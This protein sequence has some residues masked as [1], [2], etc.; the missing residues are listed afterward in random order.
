MSPS[1]TK[2]PTPICVAASVSKNRSP[3]EVVEL[4]VDSRADNMWR[5]PLEAR[6]ATPAFG[7]LQDTVDGSLPC[8]CCGGPGHRH[9]F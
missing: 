4:D 9:T 1:M 6:E 5:E 2:S 8:R 3:V 7:G